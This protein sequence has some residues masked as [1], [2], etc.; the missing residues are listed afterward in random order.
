MEAIERLQRDSFDLVFTDLD[1]PR[2]GGMEL[3]SDIQ[4][5]KYSEA[6]IVVVSS[7][8]DE[9][10]CAKAMDLGAVDYITKPVTEKSILKVLEDLQ[11]A[12]VN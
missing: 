8:N 7:R 10:F 11:L 9:T 2:L 5:R 1:M 4:S 3:M 12:S 6:P